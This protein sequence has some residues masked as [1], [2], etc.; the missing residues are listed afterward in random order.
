MAEYEEWD[1]PA[2]VT[3]RPRFWTQRITRRATSEDTH[4]PTRSL[5]CEAVIIAPLGVKLEG[6]IARV[7][8]MMEEEHGADDNAS[9]KEQRVWDDLVCEVAIYPGEASICSSK[10]ESRRPVE[11]DVGRFKYTSYGDS[12]SMDCWLGAA[13]R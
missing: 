11:E 12:P 2:E 1:E 9:G 8:S 6:A 7:S 10:D 5:H 4:D 13:S 3:L